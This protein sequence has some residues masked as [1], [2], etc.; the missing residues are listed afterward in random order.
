MPK[1]KKQ[2]WKPGDCFLIPLA[3]ASYLVGQVLAA[4]P[5]VLNSLSCALFDQRSDGE[6]PPR[7]DL[8]RLFATLL[9]TRDLIDSGDW[10]IFAAH[11]VEV[12]RAKFPFEGLRR[13]GFVGAKV[14]GSGIVNDLANAFCGLALWD[15]WA[16][17]NYLDRLL[18]DARLKPTRLLY[19]NR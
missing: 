18:L 4:E 9:T 5:S 11:P 10:K 15:D 19:K 7:P 17:P 8:D 6:T 13:R 12:P 14:I 3:D 16:D 2:D 1:R